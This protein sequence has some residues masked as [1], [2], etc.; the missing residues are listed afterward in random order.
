[1]LATKGLPDHRDALL[2][3]SLYDF[4]SNLAN[5]DI[6]SA[7]KIIKQENFLPTVTGR[8]C[9]DPFEEFCL[10]DKDGE[11]VSFRALEQFVGDYGPDRLRDVKINT[12]GKSV[13]VIG[14]GVSG[15]SAAGGLAQLGHS[16]T[17]FEKDVH[18]GG[19]LHWGIPSFRYPRKIF[20]KE[21]KYLKNL[22]VLFRCNCLIGQTIAFEDI[23]NDFDAVYVSTGAGLS[24]TLDVDG[25]DAPGVYYADDFLRR[26][27][28]WQSFPQ[29][30]D[31]FVY[32]LGERIAIIG[33]G[34]TAC[35]CAR[36][37]LRL[38]RR[39]TM[40]VRKTEQEMGVRRQVLKLLKEEGVKIESLA[41]VIEILRN[42]SFG[43]CGVKVRRFDYAE[44]EG[45]DAWIL[46]EVAGSEFTVEADN[47]IIAIGHTA[48]AALTSTVHD[49][50]LN[51]DGTIW[52]EGDSTQTS[53]EKV[54]AGGNVADGPGPILATILSAKRAVCDIDDWL[55]DK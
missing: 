21:I 30:K 48:D 54:F 32:P 50:Q 10:T 36:V 29:R 31:E 14:S 34:N 45:E 2:N 41:N 27:N 39:V 24:K 8:F 28:H 5:G 46:K 4:L 11:R 23:V 25:E 37:C 53:L 33:S 35:D 52:T 18:C 47:V 12:T 9:K 49:L 44:P 26:F 20:E 6:A 1:M 42:G 19:V 17:V 51:S 55:N 3:I 15:L 22:S 43:A 40:I 13:A 38:G 16:V 7:L